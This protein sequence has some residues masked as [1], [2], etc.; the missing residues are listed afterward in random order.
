LR[1][2]GK[3]LLRIS[4]NN[5]MRMLSEI[6][7]LSIAKWTTAHTALEKPK[8]ESESRMKLLRSAISNEG[9][10]ERDQRRDRTKRGREKHA[11]E[12]ESKRKK[13][14]E[15]N[16][17]KTSKDSVP[18]EKVSLER[19]KRTK[20]QRQCNLFAEVS[21][22]FDACAVVLHSSPLFL[23]LALSRSSLRISVVFP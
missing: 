10:E 16:T 9:D 1:S 3:G 4:T 5:V 17:T 19:T 20:Q 12:N 21:S 8:P 18:N 6:H 14:L 23:T 15:I 2:H 7:F 13:M 22:C 11:T